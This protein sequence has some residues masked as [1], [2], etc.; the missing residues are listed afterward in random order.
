MSSHARFILGTTRLTSS[1]LGFGPAGCLLRACARI[2]L[3]GVAVCR[4]SANLLA[5]RLPLVVF[6]MKRPH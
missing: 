2:G 3:R 1:L 5:V 4:F 6:A